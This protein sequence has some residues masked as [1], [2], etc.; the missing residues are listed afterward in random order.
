MKDSS[1]IRRLSALL[2][3]SAAAIIPP[4]ATAQD[5]PAGKGRETFKTICTTC[6]DIET[7]TNLRNTRTGW[8][9]VI[10]SMK[11]NGAE[12]TA[13]QFS[14][15]IEYLTANFG[16]KDDGSA[17]KAGSTVS[18]GALSLGRPAPVGLHPVPWEKN[19][20]K[21]GQAIYRENCVVCHDVDFEK[22]QKLGP[23]F[24]HLFQRDQMPK[25]GAKPERQ[26]I[27]GKI[28]VGGKLMPSFA[29]ILTSADID[30][31]LDYMQTK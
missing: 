14:E 29:K 7:T 2:L 5:L 21:I 3:L 6:H 11:S 28:R 9:E 1:G 25:S 4:S 8:V 27:A 26:A 22:S 23:S 24:Y 17:K 19:R 18:G 16:R 30:A 10:A 20:L 15:V 13:A 12:G 31:I